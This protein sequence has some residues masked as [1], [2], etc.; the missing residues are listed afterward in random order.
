MRQRRSWRRS[1]AALL[2]LALWLVPGP[3]PAIVMACSCLGRSMQAAAADPELVVFTGIAQPPGVGGVPVVLT[4]WFKGQPH[5][6]VV[7]LDG[8][9]FVDPNGGSCGTNAPLP[10]TEW[11]FVSER[12]ELG[13]YGVS[14][15]SIHAELTTESGRN[16]LAEAVRELGPGTLDPGT[17][18]PAGPVPPNDIPAELIVAGTLGAG[19]LILVVA[20]LAGTVLRRRGA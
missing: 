1:A 9:G 2:A 10:G 8:R 7:T 12:N 15:C 18:E 20:V 4:R 5:E 16:L 11:I 14:A 17:R 13:R 6:R 19:V 3:S